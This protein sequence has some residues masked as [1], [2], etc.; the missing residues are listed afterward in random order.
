MICGF[1]SQIWD[2]QPHLMDYHKGSLALPIGIIPY[3]EC[4]GCG[5]HRAVLKGDYL[6]VQC[7]YPL[8]RYTDGKFVGWTG[9]GCPLYRVARE[10]VP[11]DIQNRLGGFSDEHSSSS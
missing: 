3:P 4:P 11:Q 5:E 7:R 10:S 6:C 1:R 9:P 2:T 8:I